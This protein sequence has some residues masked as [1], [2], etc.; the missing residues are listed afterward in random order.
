[1]QQEGWRRTHGH[2]GRP[3]DGDDVRALHE[4]PCE[5]DLARGR[6]VRLADALESRS[7][8][9]D[10]RE[11]LFRVARDLSPEVVFVEVL[12]SFLQPVT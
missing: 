7:E 6:A 10:V 11:V 2:V 9:E 3:G 4:E 12:W 5:R 1:M 8:L